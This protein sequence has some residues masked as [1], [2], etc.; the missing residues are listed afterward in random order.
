MFQVQDVLIPGRFIC[1]I[2]QVLLTISILFGYK[3][4]TL[5]MN[6]SDSDTKKTEIRLFVLL[7]FFLFFEFIEFI[8]LLLGYTLFIDLLSL[9]QIF[10]HSIAVILLNWLYR[11]VSDTD[12]IYISFVLG[13]IIP[14]IFEIYNLVVLCQSNRVI[15]KIR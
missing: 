3:D 9:A 4:F 12:L 8:I 10:F 7:G 5:A 13:G 15:T 14:F 1:F 11:D 2:L 6:D